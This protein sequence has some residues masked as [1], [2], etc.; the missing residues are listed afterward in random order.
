MWTW[1]EVIVIK[2]VA[3][4]KEEKMVWGVRLGVGGVEC[5]AGVGW[6]GV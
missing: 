5:E 3:N 1:D 2:M 6:C 4:I